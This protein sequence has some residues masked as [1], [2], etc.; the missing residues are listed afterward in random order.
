[1]VCS[2]PMKETSGEHPQKKDS[3]SPWGVGTAKKGV[4]ISAE[5]Q[6]LRHLEKWATGKEGGPIWKEGGTRKEF[7][8]EGRKSKKKRGP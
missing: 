7:V 6:K 8:K 4:K 1:L 2:S 3:I 5:L